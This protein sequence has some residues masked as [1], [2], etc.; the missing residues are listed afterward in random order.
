MMKKISLILAV[1]FA[2]CACACAETVE[3]PALTAEDLAGAWN[4]EYVTADGFMVQAEAY[5]FAATLTLKED[6]TAAM[7]YDGVPGEPMTWY[8]EEGRA[9]ISGYNAETDVEI[10]LSAE[11]VLEITDEIGSMFFTKLIEEAA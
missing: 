10:L 3:I 8:I 2:L 6:G 5:G 9:Y 4:M 1:L 7:D 11:G